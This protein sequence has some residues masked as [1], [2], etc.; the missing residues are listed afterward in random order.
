MSMAEF[1]FSADDIGNIVSLEHVNTSID[2]QQVATTFYVTGLGLTRDP[3][4]NTGTANMWINVGRSQFHLPTRPPQV[5][6]GRSGIVLPGRERLLQRLDAVSKALSGT[7]FDVEE[8]ND[9]VSVTCPWGNIIRVHEPGEAFGPMQLGMPYVEFDA[10][11]GS[12]AGIARFYEEILSTPAS[13]S[14]ESGTPVAH[15]SAGEGQTLAFRETG[16]EQPPFDGHHV[17]IYI[18]DFSGPYEKLAERGLISQEDN[19]HQ[20]RFID[21]VDLENGQVLFQIEHEVRSM[22]HPMYAR[23]LVNRNPLLTVM[24]YAPG[25]ENL[26][27]ATFTANQR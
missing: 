24:D 13:V 15:V 16:A 20:Y 23:P 3:Y 10:P 2:D 4:L 27:W 7:R 14:A 21:I 1:D 26:A 17:A 6:R 22:R 8:T 18:S 12:A 5:L 25:H 11:E 9:F 19:Q